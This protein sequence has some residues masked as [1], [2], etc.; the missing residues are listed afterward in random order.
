M[1][2]GCFEIAKRSGRGEV[3]EVVVSKDLLLHGRA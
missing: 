1:L 2:A 3:A